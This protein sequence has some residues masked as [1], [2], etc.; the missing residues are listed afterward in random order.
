R[1]QAIGLAGEAELVA[2][3]D[4]VLAARDVTV[5]RPPQSGA[6]MLRAIE[7]AEG[8]VFNLGEGSV[9]EAEVE[10]AGERGYSMVMG[11]APQKALAGAVLDAA[12]EAGIEVEEIGRLLERALEAEHSR[13]TAQWRALAAT[14]V[15]FDEIP[16]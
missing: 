7:T 16:E 2:M 8:S 9:T 4:R 1:F 3:A 11:Y 14:R 6:V 15:E 10:L 12:A 13:R 5:L